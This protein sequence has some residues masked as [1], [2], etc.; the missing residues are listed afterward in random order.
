MDMGERNN[1]PT[2]ILVVKCTLDYYYITW[3]FLYDGPQ[4]NF[5]V[6]NLYS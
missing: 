5:L 2:V 1:G 3:H 4:N 6:G